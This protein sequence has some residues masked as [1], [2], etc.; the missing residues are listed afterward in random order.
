V[1]RGDALGLVRRPGL[2]LDFLD[3][4]DLAPVGLEG[5]RSELGGCGY[6]RKRET[7]ALTIACTL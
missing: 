4:P 2:E 5:G 3:P 6:E 1:S 7:G